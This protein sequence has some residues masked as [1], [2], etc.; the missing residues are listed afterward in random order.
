MKKVIFLLFVVVSGCLTAIYFSFGATRGNS[1]IVIPEFPEPKLVRSFIPPSQV[2]PSKI[3]VPI[4]LSIDDL[5]SFANRNLIRQYT[6]DT[7]YLDGTVRG[8]L[9]YKFKREEDVKV[10]AEKGKIKISL[11]VKFDVRFV[12][13]VLAAIVRVPFSAKTDGEL[14]VNI[15]VKPSIRR[16][17]SI[18]TEAEVDFEWIKPPRLKVAGIQIGLRNESD[19]FLR[20]A[21]RDN[22]YRIDDAINKEVRLREV[23]QREWDNLTVPIMAADTISLHIDPRSVAASPLEITPKE[24]TLRAYVEAGIS[25]SMGVGNVAGARKKS[26]PPLEEYVPGEES[27]NLN[28]KALLNYDA[29]E[30]EAMKALQGFE[31]DM[32]ITS[33]FVRSLRIMGSGERLITAF[34]IDAADSKGTIYAVGE[35]YFDEETRVL[36]VKNFELEEGTRSGLVEKAAWLLRP[37][38]M[39]ILSG[40]LSWELGAKVDELTNDAREII[41]SRELNDEIELKGTLKS[42][43]FDGLRVTSQGIEIG[44]NLEGAVTLTYTPK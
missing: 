8:K 35:P 38:L 10:T 40:R 1:P 7:E 11:P 4:K 36:S 31:I 15:A 29:L 21:I 2:A 23:M 37:V 22:L 25:L 41:A 42:A 33:V 19:R 16:D 24:V 6:G 3:S 17:W 30:Q 26:L 5:Q 32:G 18:K 13:N 39:S 9:N 12:G 34:N 44:L 20:E 28:V 27:I 14:R 43:K